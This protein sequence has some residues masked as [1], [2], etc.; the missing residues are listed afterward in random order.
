METQL[1]F[2]VKGSPI[3]FKVCAHR[4]DPEQLVLKAKH[5]EVGAVAAQ[6][7]GA[8]ILETE[9]GGVYFLTFVERKAFLEG[10]GKLAADV[11]EGAVAMLPPKSGSATASHLTEVVDVLGAEDDDYED[12]E[13]GDAD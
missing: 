7:A 1:F 8:P 9:V 4:K 5:P 13:V 10:F 2:A 3:A 6:V 11:L 12:D